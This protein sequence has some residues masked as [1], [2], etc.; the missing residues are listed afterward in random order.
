MALLCKESPAG[1]E[2]GSRIG[3]RR[4]VARE[5]RSARESA[6]CPVGLQ[7]WRCAVA[8]C[9]AVAVGKGPGYLK[10]N[11][12]LNSDRAPQASC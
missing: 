8:V 10:P 12:R 11:L 7:G 3:R 6:L 5:T 4:F 1:K 9:G 2:I